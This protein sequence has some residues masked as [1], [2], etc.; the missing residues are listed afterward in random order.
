M[1]IKLHL[2][3]PFEIFNIRLAFSCA[4]FKWYSRSKTEKEDVLRM[5]LRDQI[6]I[7][8]IVLFANRRVALSVE[9]ST[10]FF[11]WLEQVVYTGESRLAEL[12]AMK[13]RGRNSLTC[14]IA[15]VSRTTKSRRRDFTRGNLFS[16]SDPS[17]PC[18]PLSSS[19]QSP[20]LLRSEKGRRLAPPTRAKSSPSRSTLLFWFH[21]WSYDAV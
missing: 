5:L 13:G 19:R 2:Q 20:S 14:P 9:A 21:R 12:P 10:S 4:V 7:N 16:F 1:I 17:F 18:L 15:A 3:D 6:Q 11:V 8:Y